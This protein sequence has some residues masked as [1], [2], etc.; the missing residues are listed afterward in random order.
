MVGVGEALGHDALES[1]TAR[2]QPATD[3]VSRS[4]ESVELQ[5]EEPAAIV[6]WLSRAMG[7]INVSMPDL[8]ARSGNN[9]H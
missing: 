5:L 4:P 1:T 8:S 3:G 6:E 7:L 9:A 2:D